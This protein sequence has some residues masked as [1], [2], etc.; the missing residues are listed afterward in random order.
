MN[1]KVK[2]ILMLLMISVSALAVDFIYKGHKLSVKNQEEAVQLAKKYFD[3]TSVMISTETQ[4]Q[5]FCDQIL[6]EGSQ[7]DTCDS[8]SI[9]D[10]RLSF[11]IGL[12]EA[13]LQKESALLR[14]KA[15]YQNF[16]DFY[17]GIVSF[18]DQL[19]KKD[20]QGRYEVQDINEFLDM[21][22]YYAKTEI[23]YRRAQYKKNQ[24]HDDL[25]TDDT[26]KILESMKTS[27]FIEI[28]G[29]RIPINSQNYNDVVND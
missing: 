20:D 26:D 18:R 4:Q 27:Y 5:A 2:T 8:R 16:K 23:E 9:V 1:F 22:Y 25:V 3:D 6:K 14:S 29:K 7:M 24:T 28:F 11:L 19:R 10:Y 21:I 13:A 12:S 15:Y 17:E